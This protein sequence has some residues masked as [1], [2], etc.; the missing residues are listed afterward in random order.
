MSDIAHAR[1][2]E[3][4]AYLLFFGL[5]LVL[6]LGTLG[7]LGPQPGRARFSAPRALVVGGLAG[8]VG[9]WAFGEWM[10]RVGF[11]PLVAGLIGSESRM[12]RVTLHLA[13]AVVIGV[14]FGALFRHET[15]D[16]GSGIAGGCSSGWPGGS[17][18][19]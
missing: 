4:V 17:W 6:T 11:F 18:A 13:I 15:P 3:L 8:V 2:P 12:V 10:A 19:R 14:S 16:L 5:P 9:G 7:G 1:F